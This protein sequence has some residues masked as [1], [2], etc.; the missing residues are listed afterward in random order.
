[1]PELSDVHLGYAA[2]IATSFLWTGT[3]LFFTAAGRR[4]GPTAVNA[5][6]IAMAVVLLGFIHR[7]LAGVWFPE[8]VGRQVLFLALSGVIGLSIGDQA[9]FTAFVD[10]GPRIAMLVMTTAPIFATLFGW[11]ALGETLDPLAWLGVAMTVGGVAWVVAERPPTAIGRH[12]PRRTRGILIAFVAA[13]C[14][15]CGLMLSKVGMGH[16]WL[17]PAERLDPQAATFIRMIFAGLGMT[18]L[19]YLMRAREKKRAARGVGPAR[20]GSRGAGLAFTLGGAVCGPVFGVWMSL[21]AADNAPVG[22]AQTLTS[23]PPVLL[24]PIVYFVYREHVS[25]RA[26][27]GALVAVGGVAVLFVTPG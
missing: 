16:E 18:P 22:I 21:V 20:V 19:F 10:V 15:A 23:L 26:V 9:L 25:P 1:M 8:L 14:Q 12:P 17:P 5:I 13:A 3:S 4:L 2:G 11:A 7:W 6:R 24:L 27:I